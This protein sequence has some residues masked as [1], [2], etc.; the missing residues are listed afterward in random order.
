MCSTQVMAPGS[1]NPG[2]Y[3]WTPE[4][5]IYWPRWKLEYMGRNN[6]SAPT[7]WDP[8][9]D[10]AGETLSN[11]WA[12]KQVFVT[13]N[14]VISQPR[15]HALALLPQQAEITFDVLDGGLDPK[16]YRVKELLWQS[17][18]AELD[19]TVLR[20][21]DSVE[22]AQ[23]FVVAAEMPS[24]LN[25]DRI[26][27]IGHPLGGELSFSFQDNVLI[28]FNDRRI[29]YRSPTEP[30]NSGSPIFNGDWELLG[31]HHAG[32]ERM[33]RLDESGTYPANEGIPLPAIRKALANV[34]N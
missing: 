19:T 1:P 11:A 7:W 23:T 27:V 6:W 3:A 5:L 33:Q 26:Y 13:N 30:G 12:G 32:S 2:F 15:G 16:R 4:D 17:S 31:L 22:G 8:I 20:L 10:L 28:D 25:K 14:H 24:R 21:D 18:V 34:P 29:H 9:P